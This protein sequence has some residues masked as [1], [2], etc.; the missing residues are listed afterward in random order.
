MPR[1]R[2]AT[3]MESWGSRENQSSPIMSKHIEPV[4]KKVPA[5][6]SPVTD[7]FIGKFY[8]HLKN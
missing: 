2:Q 7:G 8:Q 3:K 4:I 6:K 1:S 5:R